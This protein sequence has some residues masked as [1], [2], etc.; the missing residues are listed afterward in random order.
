M[1]RPVIPDPLERRHLLETNLDP[2]RALRVA[3]GYL[4]EGRSVEAIA[5]LRSAGASDRLTAL[6]AQA[7]ADGDAFLLREAANAV[8]SAPT[9][10]EWRALAENAAAAGKDVYADQA[11]RQLGREG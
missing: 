8:R 1:A 4:A 3:E 5:F 9:P 6:R 2:T 11:R 7:V 10:D